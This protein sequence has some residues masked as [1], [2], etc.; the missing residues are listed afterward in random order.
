MLE[1]FK[2]AII[3]FCVI[4]VIMILFPPLIMGKRDVGY[5]FILSQEYPEKNTFI[6][7]V[8]STYHVISIISSI[9]FWL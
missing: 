4:A 3:F 1:K 9:S 2:P 5:G 8:Y 6:K 7:T